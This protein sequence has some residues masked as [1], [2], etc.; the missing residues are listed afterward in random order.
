MN[1]LDSR[2]PSSNFSSLYHFPFFWM[3]L[4]WLSPQCSALP[5]PSLSLDS[6]EGSEEGGPDLGHVMGT[7]SEAL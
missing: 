4:Q 5:Q 1:Y 7:L 3:H 2:N 6:E